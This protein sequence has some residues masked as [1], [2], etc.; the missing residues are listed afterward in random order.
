MRFVCRYSWSREPRRASLVSL[1]FMFAFELACAGCRMTPRESSQPVLAATAKPLPAAEVQPQ[2]TTTATGWQTYRV[3]PG[4]TLTRIAACRGVSVGEIARENALRDPDRILAGSN[5]RV[6]AQDRCSGEVRAV[7]P[8]RP[9]RS[10]LARAPR[11]SEPPAASDGR[12]QQLL[13]VARAEYDAALF[14]AALRGAEAAAEALAHAP[15]S[16]GTDARRVHAHL[17]AGMAAAGLEDRE[18][19]LAEFE[20]AFA[21]DPDAQLAFED[22]SPRLVEL[23]QLAKAARAGREP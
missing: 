5:L 15:R 21:L 22:Q 16:A 7:G 3:K 12:A 8:P 11:A 2:P 1:A 20:R 19:A 18:R 14:D 9:G 17:L 4:D 6:P 10:S 13:D 23:L